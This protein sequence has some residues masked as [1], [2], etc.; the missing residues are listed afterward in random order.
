MK[1]SVAGN[2]I[3]ISFQILPQ[4]DWQIVVRDRSDNT[5]VH[6]MDFDCTVRDDNVEISTEVE[7]FNAITQTLEILD[8][9]NVISLD[10]AFDR[11]RLDPQ[12]VDSHRYMTINL[13]GAGTRSLDNDDIFYMC[14]CYLLALPVQ[15]QFYGGLI[16]LLS[17]RIADD[18]ENRSRYV[19]D[20]LSAHKTF[21]DQGQVG[22]DHSVRWRL[23]ATVNLT[24]ILCYVEREDEADKL[25]ERV[26]KQPNYN[27][28]FPLT[29]MNYATL[30]ML[31]AMF[32]VRRGDMRLA[33]LR[34]TECANYCN[35]SVT[36]LFSLRNNFYFQHELDV[37]TMID[38]GYQAAIGMALL[39][40]ETHPGDSKM[41]MNTKAAPLQKLTFTPV[42]GRFVSGLKRHPRIAKET[43]V[44][45][46]GA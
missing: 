26:M 40:G 37:R 38:L 1:A 9:K 23:S 24:N 31:A 36:D 39:S 16:T 4:P 11:Y 2:K 41:T 21:L 18:M 29:Y 6:V 46:R 35:L 30:L 8:G 42:F 32:S 22:P 28:I 27:G 12:Q 17:F 10:S 25:V 33:Y 3:K 14:Y 45:L 19:D 20:L 34:F 44:I 5:N 13:F 7:N 15:N 43:I